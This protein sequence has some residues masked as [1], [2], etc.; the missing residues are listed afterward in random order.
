M[1]EDSM[2]NVQEEYFIQFTIFAYSDRYCNN[3][4]RKVLMAETLKYKQ[5]RPHCGF[6]PKTT[7]GASEE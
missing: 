2:L 5:K 3:G 7:I 4:F 6:F 1:Q